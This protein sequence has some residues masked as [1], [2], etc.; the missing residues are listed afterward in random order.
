MKSTKLTDAERAEF[1]ALANETLDPDLWDEED[2]PRLRANKKEF[3]EEQRREGGRMQPAA[4][5]ARLAEVRVKLKDLSKDQLMT[6]A[7]ETYDK[8]QWSPDDVCTLRA[9][10]EEFE[11]H[12]YGQPVLFFAPT[13]FDVLKFHE[14]DSAEVGDD[15]VQMYERTGAEI[16]PYYREVMRKLRGVDVSPYEKPQDLPEYEDWE[17]IEEL[18]RITE[19][20]TQSEPTDRRSP[21]GTGPRDSGNSSISLPRSL[22]PRC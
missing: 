16:A 8:E 7:Q 1:I 11:R 2:L 14:I 13:Y 20:D 3:E 4:T 19:Q 15:R 22:F 12:G 5:D 21:E 9:C 10:W 18:M 6:L 17:A